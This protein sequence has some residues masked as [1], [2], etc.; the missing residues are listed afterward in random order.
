MEVVLA[1]S[2]K[3]SQI[4]VVAVFSFG[5][6]GGCLHDR[7]A[8]VRG[9]FPQLSGSPSS[10]RLYKGVRFHLASSRR[11]VL[12]VVFRRDHQR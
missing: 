2:F 1:K 7:I 5:K 9:Q 6:C 3:G 8:L 11:H 12:A 10:G 4:S